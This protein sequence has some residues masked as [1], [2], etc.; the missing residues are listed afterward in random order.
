MR[1][2]RIIASA[3]ALGLTCTAVYTSSAFDS[4]NVSAV[5][6]VFGDING[7]GAVDAADAS[8][9]LAY[10]SYTSTTSD[11]PMLDLE[12]YLA[13]QNQGSSGDDPVTP[14][15]ISIDPTLGTDGDEFT[16]VSWNDGDVPQQLA[17]WAGEDVKT[18]D[19]VKV[20]NEQ[21]CFVG[22]ED[23]K[24]IKTPSGKPVKYVNFR[25]GG[26]DA[27]ER[28]DSYFN[29]GKDIDVYFAETDWHDVFTSDDGRSLDLSRLGITADDAAISYKY[30]NDIVKSSTGVLKTVPSV[31]RSGAYVYRTDLAQE[32]LGV[33]TP[34]EM[35]AKIGNW[36][37]FVKTA[38]ELT[39]NSGGELALA[40]SFGGLVTAYFN[41]EREP[42]FQN[43]EL[44][45]GDDVKKFAEIAMKLWESGG[46]TRNYQWQSE[47]YSGEGVMGYFTANWCLYE[48]GIIYNA[49]ENT[50]SMG[51]WSAV[52]GPSPFWW[53]GT[54]V[55][56]NPGTDNADDAASF[57]K[58]AY[59]SQDALTKAANCIST[60]PN[61]KVAE[62]VIAS[63]KSPSCYAAEIFGGGTDFLIPFKNNANALKNAVAYSKAE[64]NAVSVVAD[65]VY[66]YCSDGSGGIIIDKILE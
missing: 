39:E 50:G 6:S 27:A 28:Y 55:L 44:Y 18:E 56:V 64:S 65:S 61:D 10:Y 4:R 63:G 13:K 46:M 66:D 33:G 42:V 54:Y 8:L 19:D 15:D 32:Y 62:G 38:E 5:P 1:S 25:V 9:L 35:Q 11:S 14:P 20:I 45:I 49:A 17:I 21:V 60:L 24:V 31:V 12:D 48:G 41:G 47:W 37:D 51:K 53:G 58:G 36:D 7:D 40:D 57:I 59:L 52:E 3:A 43:D 26:G 16:V 22:G 29:S 23:E 2:V 30:A 34:E